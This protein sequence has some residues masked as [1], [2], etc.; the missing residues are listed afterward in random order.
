[1]VLGDLFEV[2]VDA[3][4]SYEVQASRDDAPACIPAQTVA[5][6]HPASNSQ[7]LVIL[8][9]VRVFESI[10]L[11]DYESGL[12]YPTVAPNQDLAAEPGSVSFVYRLGS[13]PGLVPIVAR[14]QP[15]A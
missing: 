11:G 13:K 5:V 2:S 9:R 3:V 1:V 4:R 6:K 10:G 8:T 12:T 15:A 7:Q 14:D